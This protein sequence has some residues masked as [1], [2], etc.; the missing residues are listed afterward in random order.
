MDEINQ[1]KK[2]RI[3]YLEMRLIWIKSELFATRER[4]KNRNTLVKE[5]FLKY[6]WDIGEYSEFSKHLFY[7][8][9]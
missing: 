4:L 6:G 7:R 1:E 2:E 9:I 5:L 8:G 3:P